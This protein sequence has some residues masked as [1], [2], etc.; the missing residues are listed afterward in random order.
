MAIKNLVTGNF[1]NAQKSYFAAPQQLDGSGTI[2]GHSHVCLEKLDS[3]DQTTPTDPNVFAFFKGLNAPAQG[4]VLTAD[5]TNGVPAGAYRLCSI[6]AAA[7]H[8]PVIVPIAQHGSLDDCIYF[9]VGGQAAGNNQQG[10]QGANQGN[11]NQGN[12]NGANNGNNN[13][14]N[15]NNNGANQGNQGGQNGQGQQG[16]Q[17]AQNGQGQQ[18]GQQQG[19]Q[20]G[21]QN[22]QQGGGRRGG[23]RR[24]GRN[25]QRSLR[26]RFAREMF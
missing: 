19:Q 10:N 26:K 12:N 11:A 18:N 7:N 4:G 1:V 13:G 25:G 5:V 8:Q 9:T 20:N 17:G 2:I 6:N 22:G 3:L 14:A 23:G 24:G 15:Q 21:Q 16:N